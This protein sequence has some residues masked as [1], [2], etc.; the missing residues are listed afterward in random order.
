VKES[1]RRLANFPQQKPASVKES[2]MPGGDSWEVAA[3]RK[4][5]VLL[6]T[7]LLAGG[8]FF[9]S[10][11]ETGSARSRRYRFSGKEKCFMRKIN[12]RRARNGKR[13]LQWDRH[14]A[15]V[16]RR[17]A[18]AMGRRRAIWHND[19]GRLVTRWRT[20]GQNVGVG[21]G[22]RGLFKAFWRSPPHRSNILH[23]WRHMGVG[24]KRAGGRIWVQQIFESRRNPGN[25]F[26]YP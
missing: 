21:N 1:K 5:F 3:M 20:L 6:L 16:A 19:I 26:H 14:L 25:V 7:T 15:Y 11:D 8:V 17:H 12:N 13:R 18:G 4:L 23:A 22:C 24:V 10:L 9:G 2:L